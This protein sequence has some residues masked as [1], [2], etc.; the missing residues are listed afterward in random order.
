MSK[1]V[2]I[3]PSNWI[4]MGSPDRVAGCKVL[5]SKFL[6]GETAYIVDEPGP[7][8]LHPIRDEH[9]EM[10]SFRFRQRFDLS[11]L[12]GPWWPHIPLTPH[13]P[14]PARLDLAAQFNHAAGMRDPRDA[15]P[16]WR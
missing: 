9:D 1:V 8:M 13:K 16:R 14:K 2:I 10:A 4:A 15:G 3:S 11:L 6:D 5:T 12:A 7:M